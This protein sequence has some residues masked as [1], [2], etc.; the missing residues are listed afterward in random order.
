MF[1]RR[2]ETERAPTGNYPAVFRCGLVPVLVRQSRRYSARSVSA[3][4][5]LAAS[6]AGSQ[7]AENVE[8]AATARMMA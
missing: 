7:S 2:G 6:R 1:L 5:T 4:S 8:T 3:G